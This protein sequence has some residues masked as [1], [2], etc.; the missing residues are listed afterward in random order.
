[1]GKRSYKNKITIMA[2][3]AGMIAAVAVTS[4]VSF[5]SYI[6]EAIATTTT[7]ANTQVQVGGGNATWF[8]FGY[9]PQ[10]V[11]IKAG[12]TVVWNVPSSLTAEPHTVTFV[13]NNKTMTYRDAPFGF[14]TLTKFMSLPPSSNSR[15]IV[16]PGSNGGMNTVI[17]V[18]G[19]VFNPTLINSAG[20]VKLSAPNAKVT[21]SGNE[22][23]VNSGW[24]LPKGNLPPGTSNTFSVTFEKAGTYN[25][26][27]ILHPWMTGTVIVK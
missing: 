1:M 5:F 4:S 10:K 24:L 11:E 13:F 25:Y 12:A 20:N 9:N 8:F 14:P 7:N 21:I 2:L 22:Q 19:R 6:E 26:L 18:N 17:L 16:S 23:Y 27:C 3:I 15:P